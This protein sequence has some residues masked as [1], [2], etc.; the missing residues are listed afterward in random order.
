MKIKTFYK[1][2]IIVDCTWGEGPDVLF[3]F[4][5]AA[6]KRN[7][8]RIR[9]DEEGRAHGG[10]DLRAEEARRIGL[11]LIEAADQADELEGILKNVFGVEKHK[12]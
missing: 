10:F 11:A 3:D 6:P 5:L 7:G 8:Q 12:E 4:I 2:E 1:D 9:I